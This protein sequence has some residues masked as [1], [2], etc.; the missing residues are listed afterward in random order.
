M[1]FLPFNTV[2]VIFLVPI[3][4]SVFYSV[5]EL[6]RACFRQACVAQAG[7]LDE[8][9]DL[10]WVYD[11]DQCFWMKF[12]FQGRSLRQGGKSKGRGSQSSRK[13]EKD[14]EPAGFSGLAPKEEA[15][16]RS[17]EREAVHLLARRISLKKK[18]K[19]RKPKMMRC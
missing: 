2:L 4:H 11:E 8:H 6:K 3:F 15:R 1:K 9:E 18:L 13:E 19:R 17:L 16:A 14:Q 12:P 5:S 10:F 7:F